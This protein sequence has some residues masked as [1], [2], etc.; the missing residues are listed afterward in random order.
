MFSNHQQYSSWNISL[1]YYSMSACQGTKYVSR[2][3]RVWAQTYII[4]L[5]HDC[6]HTIITCVG[7]IVSGHKRVRA[8]SCLGTI[9]SGHNRVWAQ[10][11]LGTIVSGHNRVGSSMYGHNR[12]V[13]LI[14]L[15]DI[16]LKVAITMKFDPF[17]ITL[18]NSIFCNFWVITKDYCITGRAHPILD[19]CSWPSLNSYLE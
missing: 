6:D 9:M 1:F 2:N 7:T 14:D 3:K 4:L 13:S 5:R 10:S 16:F 11:C 12:V 8:Q 18:L 19:L 15:S 17:L